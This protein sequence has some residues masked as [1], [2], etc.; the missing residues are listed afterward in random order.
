MVQDIQNLWAHGYYRQPERC[1]WSQPGCTHW[2]LEP[3]DSHKWE[4]SSFPARAVLAIT[5]SPGALSVTCTAEEANFPPNS[6][7]RGKCSIK[8]LQ[9]MGLD[10]RNIY[11]QSYIPRGFHSQAASPLQHSHCTDLYKR[12]LFHASTHFH[13]SISRNRTK[14][15]KGQPQRLHLSAS[16]RRLVPHTYKCANK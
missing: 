12:F 11:Y 3:H 6:K 2:L 7:K 13:L 15:L 5:E 8:Y 9:R 16:P 1:L 10:C 4:M 14:E